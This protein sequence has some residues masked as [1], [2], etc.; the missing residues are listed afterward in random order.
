MVLPTISLKIDDETPESL[1]C[2]CG[3]W[4][5]LAFDP[6]E[7]FVDRITIT[8]T[9]PTLA[10]DACGLRRLPDRA[11]VTMQEMAR[12][13]EERGI[14]RVKVDVL[15]GSSANI[16]FN[17]CKSVDLK[18]DS[19]DYFNFPGLA[20]PHGPG[21]LTPVF[22]SIEILPYFQ[23]HPGY[24]VNFASDTYGTIY[25]KDGGYISFGL[26]R[27]KHLIMWLG[28]LDKLS[29][30]DLQ[31]LAAHNIDSDH[32]IGSEFYQGQ[33]EVEFTTF[34]QERRLIR[35][36]GKFAE[37]LAKDFG[38]LRL[39]K[40]EKEAIDLMA[41]LRRPVYFT[42]EEFGTSME[43]MTKLFVER[44]DVEQ[45]RADLKPHLSAEE[46]KTSAGFRELKWLQLW[47]QKR[48]KITNAESV[49]MPLFV[50]YDLRVAYKHLL[51]EYRK[52]ELRTSAVSRLGLSASCGLEDIYSALTSTIE[53][54]F[55][56]MSAK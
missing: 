48:K 3:A 29:N 24:I 5:R 38:G 33:I 22:F 39:L 19:L 37:L 10:C 53:K 54:S 17:F 4:S 13:A 28:D 8:G 44:I 11:K 31:M 51:P 34:S 45:L 40:M 23:T 52:E 42:Q 56:Q 2:S 55:K 7:L 47:L 43:T 46:M 30:R 12:D 32:D 15:R 6:V 41:S 21:F 16:R 36:Q 27:A 49:M 20:R 18:Y 25:T 35:E 50:L 26:T 9:I 1:R 14:T